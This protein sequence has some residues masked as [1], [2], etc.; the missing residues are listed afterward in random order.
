[1]SNVNIKRAVENIRTGTSIYTPLVE[2]IVNAI[3]AIEAK[4]IENGVINIIVDRGLQ[5]GLGIDEP[6]PEI[7]GFT[8]KDNGIGFT[9]ANRESF[10]TLYSDQKLDQGGKGFGR[11]TCLKYFDDLSVESTY[12]ENGEL[13]C[14]SFKMGKGND[15]IIDE[16]VKSADAKTTGAEIKLNG[17]KS[18]KFQDKKLTTVARILVEKLL[19]YFFSDNSIPPKI[20]LS[21]ANNN[22]EIVLN[23]YIEGEGSKFIFEV[24]LSNSEFVLADTQSSKQKFSAKVFKLYYPRKQTSRISLVAHRREVTSTPLHKYIPEFIE[25]FYDKDSQEDENSGRNFILKVYVL[26]GYLDNNVSLER[27][28][29]EFQKENDGLYGIS[30]LDIE[31]KASQLAKTVVSSDVELRFQKKVQKVHDYVRDKAPWHAGIVEDVDLTDLQYGA[32]DSEIEL[33]LH[34]KKYEQEVEIQGEVKRLLL[35]NE[36]DELRNKA[37]EVVSRISN[38]SKNDLAHYVALR[39]SVIDLFKKSLELD[40]DGKYSSEGVVHDIIFPRKGDSDKTLFKEHNLWI[41][42][43]R[44]NFTEYLSSDIPLKGNS[45][46]PDLLSYDN[47]VVFRGENQS[48]NPVTIFEF[49]RPQREDFIN[50]SSDEDPIQQVI[51]Y[52][53]KIKRGD[54]KTPEG[55]DINISDNTPFYGYVVCDLS[56]KVKSWLEEEKDFKPMPDRKGYFKWHASLNL[57]LEV[58]SWDKV[59]DDATMRNRVFFHY[60]GI[61]VQ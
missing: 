16:N 2:V 61:P 8:I 51:R 7:E 59:L 17:I 3:Q 19:P 13:L 56:N 58:L 6:L 37:R 21:E 30:Q 41:I 25:E 22:N 27:G 11:F 40:E 39:R 9:D 49:K 35:D 10:D 52:A 24:P 55:R 5:P 48:S 53:R 31:Q 57:Y 54:F 47:R 43:E 4:G 42:D 50:P 26:G 36:P 38:N 23:E 33:K 15:I 34:Q 29:F 1:M 32:S 20:V 28:G 45:D 18:V 14:R 60:L 12:E 44:L 46:R